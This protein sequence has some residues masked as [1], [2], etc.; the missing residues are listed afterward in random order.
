MIVLEAI[1]EFLGY[2]TIHG[3]GRCGDSKYIIQRIFWCL[4]T[5]GCM[6]FTFYQISRLHQQYLAGH[7]TTSLEVRPDNLTFPVFRFCSL[8]PAPYSAVKNNTQL[9]AILYATQQTLGVNL[10][11][12]DKT[13]ETTVITEAVKSAATAY[14]IRTLTEARDVFGRT[15]STVKSDY[16]LDHPYTHNPYS[17]RSLDILLQ[18]TFRGIDCDEETKLTNVAQGDFLYGTCF[19]IKAVNVPIYTA[20]PEQGLELMIS[21]NHDEFVPFIAEA[22]GINTRIYDS[23]NTNSLLLESTDGVKLSAG[24]EINIAVSLTE[25]NRKA[26]PSG[27]C[28]SSNK[29]PNL[30]AC[31]EDCLN[32]LAEEKC[33]S[34]SDEDLEGDNKSCN[35]SA[36][37]ECKRLMQKSIH[38]QCPNCKQPCN[39]KKFEQ[40]ITMTKWPSRSTEPVIRKILRDKNRK[41]TSLSDNVM[42]VRVYFSSLTVQAFNEEE[43]YTTE[44]F[45]SDIGGQLGLWI[46]MSVL[47]LAEIVELGVLI[48]IGLCGV[49][50]NEQTQ[51]IPIKLNTSTPDVVMAEEN[52]TQSK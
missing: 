13:G 19:E 42:L 4:S 44:N 43:A 2:T 7:L 47:T 26:G 32:I 50:K 39:E 23:E 12:F 20:G 1:K 37:L 6:V 41:E 18:C 27:R 16:S 21:L 28:D 52:M 34:G 29:F 3:C 31:L 10:S 14:K 5:L 36:I 22:I 38:S 35:I 25:Y 45:V 15:L 9:M 30:L 11:D 51:V 49:K 46:G 8:N 24:F 40:L 48:V 33:R 17:Y